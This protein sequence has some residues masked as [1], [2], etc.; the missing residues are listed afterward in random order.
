MAWMDGGGFLVLES[1]SNL[2][3]ISNICLLIGL[4]SVGGVVVD[5]ALTN[6]G[7]ISEIRSA[8]RTAWSTVVLSTLRTSLRRPGVR[9]LRKA[10]KA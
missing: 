9:A 10:C 4:G 7:S 3:N 1:I 6:E 5:T 8:S 2:A